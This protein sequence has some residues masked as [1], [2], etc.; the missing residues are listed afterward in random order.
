MQFGLCAD[1]S[2][3]AAAKDAG[4]TFID[5]TVGDVIK[6][7][8]TEA[9]FE[10]AFAARFASSALPVANLAVLLPGAIKLAGPEATPVAE[11]AAYV[12][13]VFARAKKIG[14]RHIAFGSGGSRRCPDGWEKAK[15]YAQIAEFVRAIAS[16]VKESGVML[17]VE[18]LRYAETNTLNLLSEVLAVLDIAEVD[19]EI[20]F[21]AD[22]FHWNEN[23]DDAS[24]L[25]FL[26]GRI[27]HTHIA[28]SPSRWAPGEEPTDFAPFAALLKAAG[29]DGQMAVEATINDQSPAGLRR[30]FK[31][32]DSAFN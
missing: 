3:A 4:F 20:G 14:I 1:P 12:A 30:I 5:G 15:A 22:G 23:K 2:L 25:P 24:A 28:T 9:E 29:Y 13:T 26:V 17:G 18:N 27:R 31:T 32:L 10:D 7:A 19:S 16:A 8:A 11:S 6:P 21:L